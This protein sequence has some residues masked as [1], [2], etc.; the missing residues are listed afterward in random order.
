M[1]L[2]ALAGKELTKGMLSLIE[3]N[4]ANPSMESLHFI[5][6]QLDVDLTDLL[7]EISPT[8][9]REVLEEVEKLYKINVIEMPDKYKELIN[10]INP[11]YEQLSKGYEAARLLEIYSYSLCHV[12]DPQ[13]NEVADKAT[14][15]YQ[16]LN[17]INQLA[18]IGIF[19]AF[20]KF[21]DCK[22]DEALKILLSERKVIEKKHIQIDPITRLDLD[23]HEAVLQF[24]V[25]NS[26]S[27]ISI[28]ESAL[29]FSKE[30]RIFYL[31]DDLY[32]LAAAEAMMSKNQELMN[33][34]L[35]KLKQYGE[36]ADHIDSILFYDLITIMTLLTEKKEFHEALNKIEERLSTLDPNSMSVPW[37]ELEKGMALYHLG[38]VE[39]ALLLLEKITI[40]KIYHPFDLSI[41]HI[42]DSYKALI[43]IELGNKAEA[44]HLAKSA[45]DKFVS[46]PDNPF[47][48][49]SNQV[50]DEIQKEEKFS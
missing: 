27:A 44:L 14:L 43:N 40:P 36:F 33:H 22:Y 12:K 42:I 25:G 50:Y 6:K 46:L 10:L 1:T 18:S 26:K 39:E 41:F 28:M 29:A 49:F 48:A 20:E 16:E 9:L 30:K 34:Y 13:W 17:L 24:A 8:E 32:R 35:L 21:V 23:Y 19:R 3:N 45:V 5:A 47:K 31:I 7:E 4:K 15:I 37:F 2:E 11:Y 38:R